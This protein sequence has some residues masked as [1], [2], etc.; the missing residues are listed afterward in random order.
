MKLT[1]LL[2]VYA[3]IICQTHLLR[4]VTAVTGCYNGYWTE[5]FDR[6]DPSGTGDWETTSLAISYF[7]D[8]MC[9]D[10]SDIQVQTL[11]GTPASN[12]GEIFSRYS[13]SEGFVCEMKNQP[14][15]TCLDY[16]VRYCCPVCNDG[17]WTEWLDRDDPSDT[18][19]WETTFLAISYFGDAMCS[20]PSAIQV[21][22]LDGIPALTTGETFSQYSPTLG[23]VCETKD[24]PDN[25]C[26]DYK[27]RYCCPECKYGKW[28]GWFDRDNPGG[29]GDWETTVHVQNK[30]CAAPSAIQVQTLGGIPA[31]TT[32][33]I[34]SEYSPDVGFVCKMA[35]QPDNTC[36]DYKTRYCCPECN[37]GKWTGW[38][39]RDDPGGTGDWETTADASHE[40]CSAPSAIE[41]QTLDGIPAMT[42]GEIFSEYSP[43][44]GFVCKIADQPDNTCLDYK[45]R[46]CCPVC[47][48]GHWTEWF[49]RDDP[50]VTGDWETTEHVQHRICSAPSAIEAQTL[51]GTPALS[52]GEI[53]FYY[54]PNVGF[55]CRKV[56]QPDNTCLD[57]KTRYCCPAQSY[58]RIR[59]MPK[60]PLET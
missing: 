50:S 47:Y 54:N 23:F 21:Q 17:Y 9:S 52:T 48:D 5:W 29:T 12:T 37:Y 8:K 4:S 1:G 55:V 51:G 31:L 34:F 28:T 11:D 20:D 35:D 56:D 59:L 41:A 3:A 7:G 27:V 40:I 36:L 14:Y 22:T 39:D 32:G 57:Y 16:E 49:D 18:G 45:T 33:E 42:T 10:P 13:V 60:K 53:F 43:D 6:D 2:V 58:G 25:T 15:K 44:V 30:I 26:L 46:Y 24:Q 19:D 38:F